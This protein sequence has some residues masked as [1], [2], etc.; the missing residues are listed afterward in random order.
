[1]MTQNKSHSTN[2]LKY[3]IILPLVLI[4]LF[5]NNACSVFQSEQHQKNAE[6]SIEKV[7]ANQ[8]KDKGIQFAI[9]DEVPVFPGCTGSKEVLR[10]CFMDEVKKHVNENYKTFTAET[11]GM[12]AGTKQRVS[13]MFIIDKTGNIIDVKAKAPHELLE[14]EA[15]RVIKLLPQMK[16]GK[17]QGKVIK[18]I[19]A[20]PI[21]MILEN[22]K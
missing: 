14:Q 19:Y 8:N 13:V 12:E 7:D 1:M 15:I 17:H 16:P 22:K 20:F 4:F 6:S 3:L 5:V 21:T 2:L 9:V 11:L 10:R 18:V